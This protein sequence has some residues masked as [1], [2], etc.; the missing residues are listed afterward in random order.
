MKLAEL[1]RTECVPRRT[2]MLTVESARGETGFV[3]FQ[4]GDII[5]S[6]CGAV[7]GE[8]ALAILLHWTVTSFSLYELPLGIKRTLW[9]PV[10]DLMTTLLNQEPP[11]EVNAGQAGD[12]GEQ[13]YSQLQLEIQELPG[14]VCL[15]ERELGTYRVTAGQ[16]PLPILTSSWFDEIDHQVSV[17]GNALDAGMMHRWVF[18]TE[19]VRMVKLHHGQIDIVVL[20]DRSETDDDFERECHAILVANS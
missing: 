10:E 15:W 5:E 14:F 3:Y 2:C 16:N 9:E 19:Q 4:D 18:D 6:N 17:F 12:G 8:K 7:W 20:G 1:I 11:A 13:L